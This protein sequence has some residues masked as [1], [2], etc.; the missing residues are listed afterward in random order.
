M[1]KALNLRSKT[2]FKEILSNL[3]AAFVF[4]LNLVHGNTSFKP[5]VLLVF[6]VFRDN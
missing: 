3:K 4:L 6:P 5:S 1:E 2:W